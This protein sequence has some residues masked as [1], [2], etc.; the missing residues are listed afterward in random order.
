MSFFAMEQG[1][2]NIAFE[3]VTLD[4]IIKMAGPRAESQGKTYIIYGQA[5]V[6]EPVKT[7]TYKSVEEIKAE[8]AATTAAST[9]VDKDS[10]SNEAAAST[11]VAE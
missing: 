11:P 5:G 9:A 10:A 8:A 7:F 3:A 1:S 2:K 6:V 4:E